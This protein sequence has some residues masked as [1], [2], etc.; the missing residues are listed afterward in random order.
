MNLRNLALFLAFFV[1]GFGDARG[2]FVGISKE[3]FGISASQGSLI[4]FFGAVAFGVFA[5]P[6]GLLAARK[7]KRYVLQLGLLITAAGHALPWL[8]LTRYYHLLAGVFLIGVG[9]TCL[10]V[11]GNP[12]MRD[13][14]GPE[15]FA[16]NLTFA[17]FIKSL[18][19]IAG[20]YFI[21][22]IVAA[23]LSWRGIFPAFAVVALVAWVAIT[24]VAIPETAP[25]RLA[26]LRDMLR[27]LKA[28]TVHLKV[29]GIFFYVGTEMSMNTWLATHMWLS[30]GLAIEGD[31]I[32]YGQGLFW[33]SQGVGRLLGA[34][35]LSWFAPRRFF[36]ACALA[37]LLGLVGLMLGSKDLAIASVVLCGLSFS[38]IW[39]TLF[40]LTL[41]TR[42]DRGAEIAGLAVLANIGGAVMPFLMGAITDL[43]AV[44]WSFLVPLVAFTY[45]CGL[46]LAQ[47]RRGRA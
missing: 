29:L 36:L 34:L 43:W 2:S 21:A 17:Q 1:M 41:D 44:R 19:S 9:M 16:R 23:G 45:L 40:A 31:A 11:A 22:F 13:V 35:A 37:G 28:R 42:P 7:G 25:A 39:P 30:H 3:T 18:G 47:V 33:L 15:R 4:P 14:A 26:S 46:G 27:L 20:P 10:L 6:A 5:L 32:R 12:L 38:N 24:A 8:L